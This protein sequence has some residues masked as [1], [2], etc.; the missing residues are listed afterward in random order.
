MKIEKGS[1]FFNFLYFIGKW[2]HGNSH[3][4]YIESQMPTTVCSLFWYIVYGVLALFVKTAFYSTCFLIFAWAVI[5]IL[6]H[7]LSPLISFQFFPNEL[8]ISIITM[9]AWIVVGIIAIAMFRDTEY[10]YNITTKTKSNR[11][12]TS[13]LTST[14]VGY[15]KSFKDK[16]CPVVEYVDD[17][18]VNQS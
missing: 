7:T 13:G 1:R 5:G 4:T 18:E 15:I 11:S 6:L 16:V 10:Y 9:V 12:I 3:P 2:G 17:N 14:A 8:H